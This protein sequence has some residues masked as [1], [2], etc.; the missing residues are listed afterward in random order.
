VTTWELYAGFGCG[1]GILPIAGIKLGVKSV[2][3]IDIDENAIE[4]AK[5]YFKT[6]DILKPIKLYNK[7]ISEIEE[8]GFVVICVNIISNVIEEPLKTISNKLKP[9]GK[10]FISG[11]LDEEDSSISDLLIKMVSK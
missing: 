3:A 1:T 8:T 2:V 10:L 9:S 5:E 6:N 11:V 4:N 7:N